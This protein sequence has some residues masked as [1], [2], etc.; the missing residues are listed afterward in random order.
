MIEKDTHLLKLGCF[1]ILSYL[2]AGRDSL[3]RDGDKAITIAGYESIRESA[4]D[5]ILIVQ[6]LISNGSVNFNLEDSGYFLDFLKS[7]NML[8]IEVSM[9]TDF[10]KVIK[11]K[12]LYL[13]ESL[14]SKQGFSYQD[15]QDLS[16]LSML[17]N[18]FKTDEQTNCMLV[19]KSMKIISTILSSESSKWSVSY[20]NESLSG[21]IAFVSKYNY[22]HIRDNYLLDVKKKKAHYREPVFC[23]VIRSGKLDKKTARKIRSDASESVSAKCIAELFNYSDQYRY[24]DFK[25]L[26]TQFGDSNYVEVRTYLAKNIH[27]KELNVLMGTNCDQTKRIMQNRMNEYYAQ[28]EAKKNEEG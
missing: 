28:L 16:M 10:Y 25:R 24:E 26:F 1:N 20:Y 19:N 21:I 5:V 7:L 11:D 4:K 8:G 15:R 14:S 9:G 18:S 3:G 12:T 27:P 2:A 13:L 6:N 17:L 23:G 22:E